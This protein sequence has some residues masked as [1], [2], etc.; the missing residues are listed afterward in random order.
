MAASPE[1]WLDAL[2]TAKAVF[3]SIKSGIDFLTALR[4]YRQDRDTITESQRVSRVFSTYSD[5]EI[6]SITKRLDECRRRFATE[7]SGEQR[8]KCFCSVFIDV[9]DGNGR[10]IPLIDDWQNMFRQLCGKK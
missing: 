1:T 9:A 10:A 3:E 8:S 5:E 6:S 4:K 7:G 2:A